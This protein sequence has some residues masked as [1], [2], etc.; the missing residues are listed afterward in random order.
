LTYA[1]SAASPAVTGFVL[2][3]PKDESGLLDLIVK[4]EV[5]ARLHHML[6]GSTLLVVEDLMQRSGRAVSVLVQQA[7]AL[8]VL[9]KR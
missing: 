9:P 1:A 4:P 6:R 5:Y 7:T 8:R 3:S 2:I